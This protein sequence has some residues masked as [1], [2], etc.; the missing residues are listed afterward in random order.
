MITL[1]DFSFLIVTRNNDTKRLSGVYSSIRNLYPENEIVLVYDGVEIE[2]INPL[3]KHLTEVYSSDRVYVSGGYNLAL[4]NCTKKCFVFLHDDT[5]IAP[6]FLE[7]IIPN[8]SEKQFCNFTTVEPPMYGNT[9]SLVRPIQDFGRHIDTFNLDA[10]IKFYEQHTHKIDQPVIDSPFGGF[11]MVGFKSSM[12]SVGGFDE[13]FKPYF[14]EDADLILRLHNSGFNFVQVLNSI[15]YH[16][17]SLTS[18][19]TQESEES[20]KVTSNLFVKK[21]KAPWEYI[22][23]YTLENNIPY[24]PTKFTV[25]PTNCNTTL[26]NYLLMISEEQSNFE[27]FV[28]GNRLNKQDVEVLQT[29]PYVLQS[30]EEFGTYEVGNIKIVYKKDGNNV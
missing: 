12:D 23:L 5:F 11:F 28:D 20:M 22:R 15:V 6:N 21:W 14:Y 10:F 16:M 27:V 2:N 26:L 3:D 25:I 17:G 9:D 30:I 24:I 8:I 19:G 13:Y 7:N 4:K 18:R 1:N 29:L